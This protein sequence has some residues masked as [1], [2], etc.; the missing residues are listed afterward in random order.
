MSGTDDSSAYDLVTP[1]DAKTLIDDGMVILVDVRTPDEYAAGHIPGAINI[2]NEGIS[3][4]QPQ[5]LPDLSAP[6]MVYCRT[7]VRSK[8]AADKLVAMGYQHVYD[9]SGGITNWPYD[10]TT[11]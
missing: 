2:P 4:T 10:T 3:T 9:L 6:V 11:E 1:E 7:G 5:E 8:Q